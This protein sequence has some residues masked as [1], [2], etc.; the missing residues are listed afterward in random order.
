MLRADRTGCGQRPWSTNGTVADVA[1]VW[2]DTEEGVRGSWYSPTRRGSSRTRKLSLR[3]SV[4]AELAFDNLRL[5][6]SAVLPEVNGLKGPLS[7]LDEA[8]YGILWGAVG[9]ARACFEEA[10]AYTVVREQ[11]G[12][13]IAGSSSLSAS[14]PTW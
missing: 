5:P 4:S 7:C 14:W 12:K 2:A 1:V 9:A 6:E 8:R 11:L 10:L 13:P 3:A